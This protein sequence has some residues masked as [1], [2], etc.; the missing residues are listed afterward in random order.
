MANELYPKAREGLAANTV[1]WD[2]D[3]DHVAV[4]VD[5]GTYTPNF[6]TDT[7][8]SNIPIGARI[9]FSP[10]LTGKTRAL[11]VCD[12]ADTIV[13]AVP[14]GPDIE[15]IVIV[16]TTAAGGGATLAVGAQRLVAYVD[17]ATGLPVTPNGGPINI[18]FDSGTDRVFRI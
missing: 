1:K 2:D 10:V 3:T 16:Q 12:A 8:L 5:L 15:A 7:F 18:A 11:G 13:P 14:A 6:A 4:L 17:D 9:A